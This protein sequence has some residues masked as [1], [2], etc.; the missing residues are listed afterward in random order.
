MGNGKPELDPQDVGAVLKRD[1]ARTDYLILPL[2]AAVLAH[3]AIV[4]EATKG[5]DDPELHEHAAEGRRLLRSA[6]DGA[7]DW[8]HDARIHADVHDF[9]IQ[10][11]PLFE[12][13]LPFTYRYARANMQ[14]APNA[15]H[16]EGCLQWLKDNPS[17]SLL[18]A[19]LYAAIAVTW[20]DFKENE[21][22][23]LARANRPVRVLLADRLRRL[24]DASWPGIIRAVQAEWTADNLARQALL[25]ADAAHDALDMMTKLERV[26]TSIQE[27]LDAAEARPKVIPTQQPPIETGE[28]HSQRERNRILETELTVARQQSALHSERAGRASSHVATIEERLRDA[29]GRIAALE[30]ELDSAWAD[31]EQFRA[32]FHGPDDVRLQSDSLP[33]DALAG[34]RVMLFTGKSAGDEQNEMMQAF[35][36]FSAANVSCYDADRRFP[37]SFAAD[38]I[39]VLD[40]RRMSHASYEAIANTARRCHVRWYITNRG[41]SLIAKDVVARILRER[42]QAEE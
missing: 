42:A 6:T 20:S 16:L 22:P 1:A 41:A 27:K 11:W 28:L 7:S 5:A 32:L 13:W 15:P 10:S 8:D 38:A 30:D 14:G 3:L 4:T 12:I 24:P 9:V 40:V 37:A 17:A 2:A 19:M 21:S 25:L 39:V 29:H 23:L 26:T 36:A 33:A 34:R 18:D 35:Y 31:V